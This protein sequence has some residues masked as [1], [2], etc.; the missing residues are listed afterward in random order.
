MDIIYTFQCRSLSRSSSMAEGDEAQ[1]VGGRKTEKRTEK[2]I[3]EREKE[4][5]RLIK[6]YWKARKSEICI[7]KRKIYWKERKSEIYIFQR[8]THRKKKS[9]RGKEI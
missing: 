7:F 1:E 2:E 3:L 6:I 9:L 8:Y 5:K 4:G